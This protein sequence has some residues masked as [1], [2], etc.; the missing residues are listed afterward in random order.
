M[1]IVIARLNSI[2]RQGKP[3]GRFQY[4][5]LEDYQESASN[6]TLLFDIN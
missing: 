3:Q 6:E 5:E 1:E 2:V 4:F